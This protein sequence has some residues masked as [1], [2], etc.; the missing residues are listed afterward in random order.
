MTPAALLIASTALVAL[1]AGSA[2][3]QAQAPITK[4]PPP[5]RTPSAVIG[6]ST[7]LP[8]VGNPAPAPAPGTTVPPGRRGG[9]PG[10]GAPTVPP[11]PLP[12]EPTTPPS[13][14]PPSAPRSEERPATSST[15]GSIVP[16]PALDPSTGGLS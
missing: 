12:T 16:G 3:G 6:P 11:T 7:G 10:S 13:L 8:R 2:A 4:A 5:A 9:N 15:V 14:I 1:A